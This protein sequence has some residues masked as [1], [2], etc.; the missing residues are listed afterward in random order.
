MSKHHSDLLRAASEHVFT[1][2]RDAKPENPLVYHGFRRTRELVDACKEIAKG[3]KLDDEDYETI[4]LAAWF[5]DAGYATGLDGKREKSVETLREFLDAQG[6]PEAV[7]DAVKACLSNVGNGVPAQGGTL[8][9]DVLHDATLAPLAAKSY[10][11]DSELLRLELERRKGKLYSDVDWTQQ[12]ISFFESHPFRTR[13]A[14]LEYNAR[15]AAN[16]VRLHK[17]LRRQ[18]EEAA[19]ERAEQAK[20]SKSVGKTVESIFYYLT[21]LQVGLVSLADR[22]TSTMIHVNAIMISIVVGLLLRRID[23][24]RYLLVPTLCLLTVNLVVIFFSIYSM[25]GTRSTLAAEEARTH[26]ANLLAFTNDTAV[27]L[28]EYSGRMNHLALDVPGLQKT[29]IEQ[30]YFVRKMLLARQRSM[31]LTY[32]IFIVGLALSLVVFAVALVRGAGQ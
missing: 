32:D 16:L 14:Q 7:C 10:V 20:A 4:M 18:V 11:E 24:D 22:R 9:E 3:T 15:R 30:M 28:Q 19:E 23:S 2:F 26:E 31:R 21:K 17:L 8:R 12:C 6:Q 27:S 25:R 5:Y 1:L 13:Y 29:M